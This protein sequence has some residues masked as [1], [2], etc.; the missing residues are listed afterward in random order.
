VL[1]VF[2]NIK[3]TISNKIGE[4]K[5]AVSG[6]IDKIKG[7]LG[8]DG[9]S[10]SLPKPKLPHFSVSGG[11]APWGFM[12]NGSLPKVSVEW[13]AKG[14]VF[15]APTLFTYGGNIG[16]LGEQGAEAIVPL[17]N[18]TQWLDRIAE[19]LAGKQQDTPIV[20]TV[21]GKVFAQTSI[22]TI[23]QLTRQTGTLGLNII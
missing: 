10:W 22:N 9:F 11:E 14:G 1:S 12:G 17:E 20:L 8:F 7:L 19:R 21:D 6:I 5:E 15:D 13:Y 16:G 2:T 23:N 3:T 4:A 18:N